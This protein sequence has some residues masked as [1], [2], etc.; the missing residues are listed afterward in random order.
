MAKILK[1]FKDLGLDCLPVHRTGE[2]IEEF[3]DWQID[4]RSANEFEEE[5]KVQINSSEP[6]KE[7]ILPEFPDNIPSLFRYFV[8]G[9]RRVFP[10]ADITVGK[11]NYPVLAG[12]IGVAVIER[13]EI[14][15]ILPVKEHCTTKNYI[16]FPDTLSDEDY[17][18]LE[19]KANEFNNF[20]FK[21]LRY[22]TSG[23]RNKSDN[24]KRNYT[25]YGIAKIIT[26]MHNHEKQAICE[27]SDSG[28][29]TN[30]RML[31]V[32]GA[33]QFGDQSFELEQ[34]RNVIGVSKSFQPHLSLGKGKK[35][36][37]VGTLTRT[38]EFGE[39]S[40]VSNKKFGKYNLGTW[41]LRM[42]DRKYLTSP[43]QGVVK[44]EAFAIDENEIENGVDLSRVNT[45]S[46]WLISERNVTPHGRDSRWPVHLYPIFQA[47][48]Y[49]KSHF[50]SKQ[51]L[52]GA[53]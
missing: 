45:F 25:D 18:S 29:L 12:Q 46:K 44:V 53:F 51:A 48:Q 32:D 28:R 16:V 19:S 27:L 37:D 41:Y 14:G 24:D 5:G 34:F 10:V 4:A 3:P 52:L 40:F 36:Q 30:D 50:V 42:R 11:N 22:R 9:S 7:T 39:R 23:L 49:I 20:D 13:N 31:I 8:D 15:K 26:E 35:K 47:E 2:E 21:I 1:L 17:G 6:T 43:I 38:L 33:I